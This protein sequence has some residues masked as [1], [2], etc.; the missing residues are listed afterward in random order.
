MNFIKL[1]IIYNLLK[2][3]KIFSKPE[4]FEELCV[5]VDCSL[6]G[7]KTA[8]HLES[9]LINNY[10]IYHSSVITFLL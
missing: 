4:S 5:G 2:N 1:K 9:I 8:S 10:W 6:S 7:F 3:V